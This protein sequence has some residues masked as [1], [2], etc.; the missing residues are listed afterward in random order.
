MS[1]SSSKG[2]AEA[3]SQAQPAQKY[4]STREAA[5]M[6]GLAPNT[7]GAMIESGT[8]KAWKTS[9]GHRRI[10]AES[11]EEV[12][13]SARGGDRG[14][15]STLHVLIVEDDKN[16]LELYKK[17]IAGWRLPVTVSV[18]SN[19]IEALLGI[20]Q[21]VPDLLITDIAMSQMDGI[22][23]IRVIRA[24]DAYRDMDI[25]AVTGLKSEDLDKRGGLPAGVTHFDKP[26]PFDQ[27]QG[28]I[29]ACILHRR[30]SA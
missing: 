27:L 23:M 21:A 28:F 2:T 24:K 30:V 1:K 3:A 16:L 13:R 14:A 17:K 11:L 25:I 9:G 18:A 6:L 5:A 8:L 4:Y 7:I 12:L 26:I 15:R 19:G 20:A 29:K 22:E 10:M